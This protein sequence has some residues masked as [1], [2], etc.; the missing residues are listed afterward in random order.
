MEQRFSRRD[1]QFLVACLIVTAVC[2]AAGIPFFYQAFPEA[3]ID[4]AITRDQSRDQAGDFLIKR[5]FSLEEYRHSAIF[6]YDDRAKTFL[7][8]ELGLEGAT[9]VIGSPVRL[10]RWNNRW[11]RRYSADH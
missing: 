2:L 11:V 6:R 4:F 9:E 10:W 1:F 8:R 5:G 3:S 7:E